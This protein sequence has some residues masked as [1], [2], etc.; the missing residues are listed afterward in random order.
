MSQ[1]ETTIRKIVDSMLFEEVEVRCDD[2]KKKIS[3][4]VNDAVTPFIKEN[5]AKFV[6]DFNVL[7]QLI[8]KKK[9]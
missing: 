5:V 2:E 8:A 1:L 7:A 4:F 6:A 9:Q 3:I